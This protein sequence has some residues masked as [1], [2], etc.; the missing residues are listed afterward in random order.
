MRH[1]YLPWAAAEDLGFR[2][3]SVE[4]TMHKV[5]HEAEWEE[6]EEQGSSATD[7]EQHEQG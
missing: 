2:G 1:P 3:G 4:K 7:C 6:Q 5:R